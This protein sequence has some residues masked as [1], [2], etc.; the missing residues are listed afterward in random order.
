MTELVFYKSHNT[1]ISIAPGYGLDKQGSRVQ[2][3]AG[4]GNFSH[5]HIQ[6]STGAHSV[7]YPMGIWGSFTGGK[8]PWHEAGH[9]PPYSIKVKE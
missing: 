7:S 5:H 6:N 4:A 2:F 3:L 1:S 8:Q 9:S